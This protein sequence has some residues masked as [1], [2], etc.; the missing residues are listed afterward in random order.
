MAEAPLTVLHLC[1]HPDDEAIAAPATLLALRDAGHRVV[2]FACGVGRPADHARRRAELE[3]AARRTRFELRVHEPPLAIS[4][5]DDLALAQATLEGTLDRILAD[6]E[7]SLV[8]SPSPHD[9]HPGHELVG[10]AAGNVLAR[11]GDEVP[12]WWLWGLWGDLPLPTLVTPF[13]ADRLEEIQHVLS[14]YV[15]EIARN[16]YPAMVEGRATASRVLGA[17]RVFGFGGARLDDE[18]YAEL[19]TEVVRRDSRW[20]ASGPRLL[21]PSRPL[22]STEPY[23]AIDWWLAE[24]SFTERLAAPAPPAPRR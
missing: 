23:R 20:Y 16:D 6:E 1:P 10:R 2:N 14:A 21:D 18:P 9:R 15:G 3:E 24:P 17:E 5:G 19:L 11:R 22:A 12:V 13:G 4:A 7:I 8:V